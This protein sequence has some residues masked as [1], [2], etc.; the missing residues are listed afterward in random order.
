MRWLFVVC[1]LASCKRVH[2]ISGVDAAP[3]LAI[4][5]ANRP[6]VRA[7]ST[8]FVRATYED[9]T[10]EETVPISLHELPYVYTIPVEGRT[11][12]VEIRVEALD[13]G[14]H[15]TGRGE[16]V[17]SFAA[18]TATLVLQGAD[19]VVNSISAGTQWLSNDFEASG[20]QLATIDDTTWIAVF[21]DECATCNVY[22]RLFDELGVPVAA[23]PNLDT[24]QFTI[25]QTPTGSA[26]TPA[27]A[28]SFALSSLVVWDTLDAQTLARSIECRSFHENGL[29]LSNQITLSTDLADVVSAA[30][31]GDGN[32]VVTWQAFTPTSA[33]VI[34]SSIVTPAC[35]LVA[36]TPLTIS[37]ESISSA[38]RP[39]AAANGAAVLY[40]WIG[41][42]GVHGRMALPNGEPFTPDLLLVANPD[43]LRIDYVRI[44]SWGSSFALV[45]RA[46]NPN[47]VA[48]G[49]ID[50]YRISSNGVPSG[51]P[52]R[53]TASSGSDFISNQSLGIAAQPSGILLVT[54][55]DCPAGLG[56][57]DVFGRF[58]EPNGGML[59][60]VRVLPTTTA[61][62]QRNPSATF[63]AG[64]FVVAWND[65][66][67]A[68][69]DLSGGAVR[70]RII[71]RDP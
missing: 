70:A 66:S 64:S 24:Q 65:T 3:S 25:S 4:T 41:V 57:C 10:Y 17:T 37:D 38:R 18:G 30:A 5:I 61:G 26:V 39:H 32:Y 67:G 31:I 58:V 49:A 46:A 71:D 14:G 52:Y 15:L 63:I 59:G 69:P 8:L 22:G 47:D 60:P 27:V 44:V 28:T 23:G 34:R 53:V 19:F 7:A 51:G 1:M 42:D 62:D 16:A 56:S 55:H 9:V 50:V 11:G 29:V 48:P 2:T 43:G 36:P 35:G 54:W 12:P 6:T 20:W 45:T 33:T 21:R 40:T 68:A 13:D